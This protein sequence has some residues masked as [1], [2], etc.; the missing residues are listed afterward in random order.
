MRIKFRSG[1]KINEQIVEIG[2]DK[3]S[4]STKSFTQ[5]CTYC[6]LIDNDQKDR[7]ISDH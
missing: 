1:M 5:K 7:P 6:V 2:I 4:L 3:V